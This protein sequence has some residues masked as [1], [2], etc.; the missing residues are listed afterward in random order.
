MNYMINCISGINN[1]IDMLIGKTYRNNTNSTILTI[2]KEFARKLEIEDSKVMLC[3]MET[4][5]GDC[6]MISKLQ[7]KRS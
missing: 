2:P 7:A 3:I 4:D 5:R 1:N 6:L